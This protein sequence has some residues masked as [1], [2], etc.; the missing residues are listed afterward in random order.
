MSVEQVRIRYGIPVKR[1]MTVRDPKTLVEGRVTYCP[2]SY[3]RATTDPHSQR[4]GRHPGDY[5]YLVDGVWK[6]GSDYIQRVNARIDIVNA[7]W[8]HRMTIDEGNAALLAVPT[9]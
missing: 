7:V 6:L 1:G 5:D 2:G 8:N 4:V 3:V 9:V